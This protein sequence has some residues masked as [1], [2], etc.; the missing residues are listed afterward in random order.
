MWINIVATTFHIV[1]PVFATAAVHVEW[2]LTFNPVALIT[3][4]EM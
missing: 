1:L 2:E 4:A 3:S